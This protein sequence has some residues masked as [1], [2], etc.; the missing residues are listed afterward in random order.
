MPLAAGLLTA[1]HLPLVLYTGFLLTETPSAFLVVLTTWL[2]LRALER[3]APG[4]FIL[5]GLALGAATV[6]RP[7][8]LPFYPLFGVWLWRTLGARRAALALGLVLLGGLPVLG[9]A[10][11]HNSRL[12]GKP[13]LLGTNGGLN[14]Y[15]NFSEVRTIRYRDQLNDHA[16]TPLPNLMR[17]TRD[18]R[19]FVPFYD[20]GHYYRLGLQQIGE[21]PAR[22]RRALRNLPDSAGLGT[23]AYWPGWRDHDVLVERASVGFFYVVV[24]PAL[25]WLAWLLLSGGLLR[26]GQ[27]VQSLLGLW[28]VSG[29]FVAWL[30][31][32][33]PRIRVPFDALWLLL[34]LDAYAALAA[35]LFRSGTR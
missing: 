35:R 14:F 30:F 27:R 34:A 21:R 15:L 4:D 33:D 28:L 10:A 8:L 32:G 25:A 17:Y 22:L 31:L 26:A 9:A 19:S 7:N 16:I 5:A 11:A 29:A 24:V 20:D 18:E 23:L 1:L 3:R 12:L 6:V 13:S 2:S